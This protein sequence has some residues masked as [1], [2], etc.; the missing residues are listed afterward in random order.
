MLNLL[1]IS[2]ESSDYVQKQMSSLLG[3]SDE[4]KMA[5]VAKLW[6]DAFA[7]KQSVERGEREIF[8]HEAKLNGIKYSGDDKKLEHEKHVLAR[9]KTVQAANVQK[10]KTAVEDA[11]K[12]QD[13]AVNDRQP[14]HADGVVVADFAKHDLPPVLHGGRVIHLVSGQHFDNLLQDT[15]DELRPPSVILFTGYNTCPDSDSKLGFTSM[16]ETKLPSRERLLVASY[17]MDA[18][19]VRGWFKFTPEMDLV[20]RFG[21]LACGTV[22]FVPRHPNCDGFTQYCTEPTK[23]PLLTKVGCD[24]FVDKCAPLVQH[25]HPH[26]DGD[27]LIW[28]KKQIALGIEPQISPVFGSYAEQHKW[29]VQR[30]ETTTDNEFRNYF[31]VESFPAFTPLGFAVMPIPEAMQEWLLSYWNRKKNNRVNEGWAAGSTQMNFHEEPTTFVS[32]DQEYLARDKWAN[33]VIKPIVEKWSGMNHLELTS[34]YGMREYKS[35][36]LTSKTGSLLKSHIDRIDTHVLSV[37]FTIAKVNSSNIN[38]LL[39]PEEEA[40]HKPWPLEVVAFDGQIYRHEHLAGT[41]I[42]YESSKLAHGRPYHNNDGMDHLGCFC[43][44]KPVNKDHL[45]A[46]KWDKIASEARAN[47]AK[48]TQR[49]RYVSLPVVEPTMPVFTAHRFGAGTGWRGDKGGEDEEEEKGYQITF[50]NNYHTTLDLHWIGE[51]KVFQG[52]LAPGAKLEITSYVGH[53]FAWSEQGKTE[54]LPR[55]RF[56]IELGSRVY[57]YGGGG[58]LKKKA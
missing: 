18:N 17:D 34:F 6:E 41:M 51:G 39:T 12:A 43:H 28:I 16:A 57:Q 2:Q 38:Q 46:E 19:P 10:Y 30:D 56:E 45:E 27:L 33:E 36:N 50:V 54:L 4:N 35:G 3:L 21:V 40:K 11:Q 53:K 8:Q 23:D 20:K 13:Q 25:Y 9:L 15:P 26:Q 29:L 7:L 44:F 31:L 52:S 14:K 1:G 49:Q 32:L 22:V 55:G 47:Q 42:L 58:N 24:K 37:T 48:N 5:Q